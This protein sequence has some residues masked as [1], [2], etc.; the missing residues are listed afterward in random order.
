M[1][2]RGLSSTAMGHALRAGM[3]S[4]ALA[5]AGNAYAQDAAAD[6]PAADQGG[7]IVV[8]ALKRATNLQDTP[9]SISAV[10]G[11]TLGNMGI[12]D[13][14]QLARTVPSLVF[15]ESANGGAR[16]II[17]NIQ[18][19]GEPTVG[20]YY[21]ETPLIGSAGVSND[22]G[23]STPEV[24]LFDVER[25]EVLRG[26]Q[27]T[28]YGSGSMAGTLRLIFN[29]PDMNDYA[30]AAAAQ[31]STM[32]GGSEGYEM[33]GMVN[34]PIINDVLAMRVVGFY[35]DRGGWL[36]NSRLGLKNFNDTTSKGGRL[37]VRFKPIEDL[38]IDGLAMIQRTDGYSAN[39]YFPT[40]EAGG[41]AYDASYATLQ[42]QQDD[43]DLFSGTANW[44]FG[45][46]TLTGVVAYSRRELTYNYDTSN[47]FVNAAAN[48]T[49]SSAGCRNYFGIGS[50]PCT[51]TQLGQYRQF[52]LSQ[53]PSTA[54]SPQ[55]TKNWS[56]ELRLSGNGSGPLQWTVGVFNALRKT[57]I[58]SDVNAADPETG[59]MITPLTTAPVV[60]GNVT[61]APTV[62]FRRTIDDRLT[63]KAAFG[64]LTYDLTDRLSLTG[65][66]RYFEYE[67]TVTGQ[68]NV[69][70][71]VIGNAV[72]PPAT[73]KASENGWVLKFNADYKVTDDILLYGNAAQG[74]RPGGVNQVIGLPDALGPYTSDSLWSYELGLK[75]SWLNRAL[76][77]N[78]DV[79]QID[80]ND[81]QASA[82]TSSGQANGSTFSFITNAGDVRIRGVELETTIRPVD[83]LTLTASGSY[84]E[85][86]LRQDQIA[87]AG[88]TVTGAGLKGD[89]VPYTP[90]FSAQASA[91]YRRPLTDALGGLA[92]L[93][94]AHVGESWS[95]FRRTNAFQQ[96]IPAYS[97]FNGRL[98]IDDV[99]GKWS[100]AL[101]ANNIFD[102]VGLVTKGNGALFGGGNAVRTV[103]I[104]PRTIGIDFRTNF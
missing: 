19:S 83:G 45:F 66:A 55:L 32:T 73:T 50:V 35:R 17:R 40:Y 26:P 13:S 95:Q 62:F 70:N 20:L 8:T 21:D 102:K 27:G 56:Q 60:V 74:F 97:T 96:Q 75:T 65:G 80:W 4:A 91:E 6:A 53:T 63:Q 18:S 10:T 3:M 22:A 30:G 48:A 38:T 82:N 93:D 43:L 54:Y 81:L 78:V 79:F 2:R 41:K 12:T 52:A 47:Y 88:I 7:D 72:Q 29:K 101:F 85:A 59:L 67:K 100:V 36:D 86:K 42:P 46:A 98:G 11:E 57:H 16:I 103:S 51:A 76:V 77:V 14:T 39:W 49:A 89:Y 23:G 61:R 84:I 71:V 68:V 94:F 25:V 9:L 34:V 37:L 1:M 99:D 58:V 104:A 90:K 31:V 15:R 24:R 69:G 87:P 92:R 5:F 44:D 28:L 33:Q 64:E